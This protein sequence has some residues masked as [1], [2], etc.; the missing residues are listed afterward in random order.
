MNNK[1]AWLESI[2]DTI[3]AIVINFPISVTMVW[4]CRKMELSVFQ[5]SLTFTSVFTV[6]AIVRKYIIRNYFSKK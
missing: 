2:T 5:T 1:K 3:I 4:F 6:I